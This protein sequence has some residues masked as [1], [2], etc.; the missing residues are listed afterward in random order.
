M[1][2]RSLLRQLYHRLVPAEPRRIVRRRVNA[3]HYRALRTA[4]YPSPKG[5]FSLRGCDD[6]RA[7]FIHTPK[8]A[9]TSIALSVFGELPYHYTGTDYIAIFGR[10]TFDAY[11]TFSFVRNPWDRLVSA[12]EYLSRGG[13]DEKDRA[14]VDT[15][16]APY[17]DFTDFVRRGLRQRAVRE[18]MHFRPQRQF[19][20]DW[21][22]RLLV[23]YL[24]YF[25]TITT[26]F[27]AI[28]RRL[29]VDATLTHTNRSTA[30]DYR[31]KYTDETRRLV[32]EHYAADIRAFG[33]DFEGINKRTAGNA[34]HTDARASADQ[35]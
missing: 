10:E 15:H 21:R 34:Q 17:A 32:G 4:V 7:I 13:W 33:Y 25:E 16:L 30:A 8:A 29:G 1:A 11:F 5:T 31:E 19:V 27:E 14:W 35:R 28:C 3:A 2:G 6:K 23:D 24:G 9:G 12:Y 20:C 22:G 18:F 26:D